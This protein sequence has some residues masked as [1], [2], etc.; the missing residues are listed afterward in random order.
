[1][2]GIDLSKIKRTDKTFRH[3]EV[4]PE[5]GG[6]IWLRLLTATE[7]IELSGAGSG[8]QFAI[9]VLCRCVVGENGEPTPEVVEAIRAADKE[10]EATISNLALLALKINGLLKDAAKD[11]K[12]KSA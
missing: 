5:W 1:M 8:G 10:H 9:E 3:C 12:K 2:A 11:A 4:V 6:P 7:H